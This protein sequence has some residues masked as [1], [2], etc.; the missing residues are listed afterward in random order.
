MVVLDMKAKSVPSANDPG[1]RAGAKKLP[2]W[3]LG[4]PDC[5]GEFTHSEVDVNRQVSAMEPFASFGDKPEF[6]ASGLSLQCPNCKKVSIYR[7][8]QLMY[9]PN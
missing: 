7:R 2:R 5:N 9:R 3:V 6:P 4:C 1:D 8:Y